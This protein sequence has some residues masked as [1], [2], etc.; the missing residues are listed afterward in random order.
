MD[1]RH[2]MIRFVPNVQGGA[3]DASYHLPA[4]YEYGLR[5]GPEED[6]EFWA[7]AADVSRGFF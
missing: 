1:E 6:R 7:K 2:L 3:T 4:F 5:W